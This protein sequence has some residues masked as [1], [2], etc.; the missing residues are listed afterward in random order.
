MSDPRLP[1][2]IKR[3]PRGYRR[4]RPRRDG[5]ARLAPEAE[6]SCGVRLDGDRSNKRPLSRDARIGGAFAWFRCTAF[7]AAMVPIVLLAGAAEAEP[8]FCGAIRS[9]LAAL[10]T[11]TG[12]QRPVGIF[13]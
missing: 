12:V 11:A 13:H 5:T 4:L 8:A 10:G 6:G 1:I 9:N 3:L 7:I 2:A